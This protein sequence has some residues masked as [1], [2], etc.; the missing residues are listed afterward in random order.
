MKN[1]IL[2]KAKNGTNVFL[3][4]TFVSFFSSTYNDKTKM[5]LIICY[6]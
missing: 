4:K 1:N 2:L 5:A 6:M 3:N